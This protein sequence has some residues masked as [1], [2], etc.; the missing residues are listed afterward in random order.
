M[1]GESM[2]LPVCGHHDGSLLR[3]ERVL[4]RLLWSRRGCVCL[5][6]RR[7]TAG[8]HELRSS[9]HHKC[10]SSATEVDGCHTSECRSA[11]HRLAIYACRDSSSADCGEQ[12]S[13]VIDLT[14]VHG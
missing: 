1:G 12:F 4:R 5:H 2:P 11:A 6:I 3:F 13:H 7:N 14:E 9:T 10:P 8:C